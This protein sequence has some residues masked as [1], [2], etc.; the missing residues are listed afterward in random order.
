MIVMMLLNSLGF[1]DGLTRTVQP[2]DVHV[3][4]MGAAHT[5]PQTPEEFFT[6]CVSKRYERRTH[7]RASGAPRLRHRQSTIRA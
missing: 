4:C 2:G 3:R 5:F 6:M 7:Q 1:R